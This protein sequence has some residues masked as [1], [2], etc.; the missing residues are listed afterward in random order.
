MYSLSSAA[1]RLSD[2]KRHIPFAEPTPFFKCG[3]FYPVQP[4][5]KNRFG[6]SCLFPLP[7]LSL[8]HFLVVKQV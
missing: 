1:C 4:L 5:K 8:W 3:G 2:A 7:I 6:I